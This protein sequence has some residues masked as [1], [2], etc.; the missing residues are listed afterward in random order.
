ML[1]QA[2][3]AVPGDDNWNPNADL[4]LD[5]QIDT[6]DLQLLGEDNLHTIRFSNVDK[7]DT[8]TQ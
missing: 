8:S 7:K 6:Q 3:G 5:S 2:F 4:N 1:K